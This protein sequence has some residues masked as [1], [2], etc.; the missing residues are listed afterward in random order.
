ME[1]RSGLIK[2]LELMQQWRRR[3]YLV[4]YRGY[5][6]QHWTFEKTY[7]SIIGLSR[8]LVKRGVNPGN[9][10]LLAGTASPEWVVA[11]FAILYRGAVVVPVDPSSSR[12]FLRAIYKKISPSLIIGDEFFLDGPFLDGL[13]LDGFPRDMK[14]RIVPFSCI[15]SCSG[16]NDA[17]IDP[18]KLT[19]NLLAEIVFT[20]GT[21]SKPK[22]VM[23]TH[24]NIFSNLRPIEIG[25]EKHKRIIRLVTPLRILNT[26]PYS[27]MFGQ[28]AAILLPILLGS[29]IY[30]T[31]D[32]TPASIVRA[33][34]RDRI[35]TL[36]TVPR[37]VK[38]LADHVKTELYEGNKATLF[39]KRWNRWIKIPYPLRVLFFLDIHRYMGL[40]FWSFV[41]GGAP[42]DHETHEFWR[43]QV[44]GLFQG[45]GLT[46]TAPIVSM[47]NPFRDKRG[48]AGK[49][50]SDQQ[51]RVNQDGEILV[52]GSNVMSGYYEDTQATASV[53]E[54][55]WLKTGDIG[56][57]K[58]GQL[59]IKGRKKD[60]IVTPDGHNVFAEDVEQVLN[61]TEGVRDA[62]VAGRHG[63]S[64][65]TVFAVLILD[66]GSDPQKIVQKANAQLRPYQ[67][68][69]GYALWKEADFPRTSTLKVRKS[70]VMEKVLQE[71]KNGPK[72][73]GLLSDFAIGDVRP[74]S[75]LGADLGMDS[76]DLVEVIGRL[77]ER[78]GASLDEIV[79]DPQTTVR[80]LQK[81]ALHPPMSHRLPMPR[82][83]R[84]KWVCLVRR[85]IMGMIILPFMR[86]FIK[87]RVCGL[88]SLNEI[89]GPRI[90]AANHTSHLDSL[91]L[92]LALPGRWR[93]R[94][95]PA[96]GLNRFHAY[97]SH[98]VRHEEEEESKREKQK[99][100]RRPSKLLRFAHALA[101]HAITFLFQTYPFPQGAAYR[102][103][104]EYTGELLDAGLWLLI[105]PEGEVSSSGKMN[106]F[107]GGLSIIA[108]RT[109]VPVFPV[110]I[111]GMRDVLPPGKVFPR[112]G[113]VTVNIGKALRYKNE[114]HEVFTSKIE[115][116]V[117]GLL[118]EKRSP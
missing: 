48:S 49:P 57:I 13:P 38:L 29:T 107:R 17:R 19:S 23:L 80:D 94:I 66:P 106:H 112:R 89:E 10:V 6:K 46:E 22:G 34:R 73:E 54:N 60:M 75:R 109:D 35:L 69:K 59:Y 45:Y 9:R 27:H 100:A 115:N 41:V 78:Y 58:E 3:T 83:N 18:S 44:F 90:L 114:E 43:G 77:E 108:E 51:I 25:V 26:V 99:K 92:L 67:K 104:L 110:G 16:I 65:E 74:D 85:V 76:L 1:E 47:F 30:F 87:N 96:M 2:Y 4:G 61:Q 98:F 24:G 116:E 111:S 118:S 103:S 93:K 79:I 20:S 31:H 62:M 36:V 21:T 39:E 28:S 82:W 97:F 84:W 33:I 7:S 56:E 88:A 81:I 72:I 5:R 37:L 55:G 12:E 105:F 91:A 11:F 113:P 53:I 101:Y 86:L 15:E 102:P 42:L 70:E 40:H 63:P 68:I 117:R 8:L 64:G 32:T 14:E 71:Q 50:L 52:K 95:A